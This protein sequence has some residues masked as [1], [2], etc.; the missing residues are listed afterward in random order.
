MF[1]DL[2]F[3]MSTSL[4]FAFT[5]VEAVFTTN[6]SVDQRCKGGRFPG[7]GHLRSML[8]GDVAFQRRKRASIPSPVQ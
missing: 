4:P 1:P 7:R 3:R 5:F 8:S 2:N 6:I